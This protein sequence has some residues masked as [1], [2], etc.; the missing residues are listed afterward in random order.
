LAAPALGSRGGRP[1]DM[2]ELYIQNSFPQHLQP[3]S[4]VYTI[5]EV[6]NPG[7]TLAGLVGADN[8]AVRQTG[9]STSILASSPNRGEARMVVS[10]CQHTDAKKHGKDKAGNPRMRCKACGK[11]WTVVDRPLGAMRTSLREAAAVLSLLLEGMSVRSA[12]RITGLKP[13]TI[14]DL[15]LIVGANCDKL[16]CDKVRGVS[17][18][19][20]Q[21][22]EIWSFVSCKEKT[23]VVNRFVGDE[24]H[25]WTWIALDSDTKLVLAHHVGQRDGESCA[26]FLGKLDRATVGRF[27]LS[28][29][30]LGAYTLNVP[31]TF[32][33]RVDFGQ[34]IK[35]FQG[36]QTSGRY[37]PAKI[38]STE[39]RAVYGNPDQNKTSTSHIERLNLTLRMSCRR[40]TRLT[41]AHS[42]SLRHHRSMQAIFFCWYNFARRHET[43]GKT[44]AMAAGLT[45]KAW[46]MR[47]V[48]AIAAKY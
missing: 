25:S 3:N 26:V 47:E 44:P 40:H 31:F 27:Q 30:G 10:T 2:P 28:S 46:T 24:G 6:K 17:A 43:I 23:R 48:I 13:N 16:L 11:T 37:S 5:W 8:P 41:N 29:D 45:D 12:A 22:D 35:N 19:F 39:K 9:L 33:D 7:E 21:C 34:V 15:I 32:R 20:V 38:I 4:Y 36:G 42:K 18:S 1:G 14:C